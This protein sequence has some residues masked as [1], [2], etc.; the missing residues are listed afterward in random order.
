M[1]RKHSSSFPPHLLLQVISQ[2]SFNSPFLCF[3]PARN[4]SC[5]HIS[6]KA[7]LLSNTNMHPRATSHI[8]APDLLMKGQTL[9]VFPAYNLAWAYQ[10]LYL[11]G[12]ALLLEWFVYYVSCSITLRHYQANTALNKW[13]I[14]EVNETLGA[15]TKQKWQVRCTKKKKEMCWYIFACFPSK[16]RMQDCLERINSSCF[17][18]VII[19]INLY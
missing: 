16:S 12:P 4:T 8:L 18:F 19:I 7:S 10:D 9:S 17:G 3:S 15:V 5:I 11:Q 13:Q 14:T 2:T 1:R 6:F